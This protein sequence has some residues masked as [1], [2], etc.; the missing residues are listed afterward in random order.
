LTP[1]IFFNFFSELFF[2]IITSQQLNKYYSSFKTI[3]VTFTKEIVKATGLYGKQVFFK[4]KQ[5]QKSCIIYS[6]FMSGAKIITSMTKDDFKLLS[7]ENNMISLR[8]SFIE[9]GTSDPILFFIQ[10][11]IS[12]FSPFNRN[13]P[14]LFLA[15]I[16]YTQRPPDDLIQILGTL[17]DAATNSKLRA[18]ERITLNNESNRKLNID[19]KTTTLLIDN[20]P[21]KCLIRDISFSGAKILLQGNAKFIVNKPVLLR[22]EV[23][24]NIRKIINIPGACLRYEEV[25]GRRDIAALGVRF[26]D[27][28][29]PLDYKILINNYLVHN[30]KK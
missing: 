23:V 24:T 12:G 16:E 5:G 19:L 17:L 20:I 9:N 30:R 11:K 1:V 15:S 6:S 10:S 8:Y 3:D 21:R 26:A 18:E 13:K 4:Y 14:D 29:I 22:I 2:S 28:G 25:E 27:L 7:D